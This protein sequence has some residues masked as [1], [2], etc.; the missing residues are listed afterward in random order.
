MEKISR[1]KDYY[2]KLVPVARVAMDMV[3]NRKIEGL[4]NIPDEPAIYAANHVKFADSILMA[5]AY[6]GH[7]GKAMR[8]GAK[9]EYFD[10]KGINNKGQF[11]RLARLL[12]ENTH[13]IPVVRQGGSREDFSNF[14]EA[15]AEAVEYGDSIGIHPE[16]TRSSDGRLHTFRHGV[17]RIAL[18]HSLPIVPVGITYDEP[19]P[20]LREAKISFG[21]PIMP[22][23]YSQMP[24]KVMPNKLKVGY[25]S[26]Q[27]ENR[28]ADL[29]GQERA[30]KIA[31]A[32]AKYSRK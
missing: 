16:G 1:E 27:V 23:E 19:I 32:Y 11:G 13:Q 8:F 18:E 6:T 20:L 9:K 21:E 31:D 30:G 28:V 22:E 7:T 2:G 25:I 3:Y 15:I 5:L 17:A 14:S 29:T 12:V 26:S 4:E 24:L 10:G